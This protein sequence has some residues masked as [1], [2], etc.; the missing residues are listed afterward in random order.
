MRAN[1]RTIRNPEQLAELFATADAEIRRCAFQ[2]VDL[3][4]QAD[5]ALAHTYRDCLFIGCPLPMGLKRQ[6]R[7]CLFF[8]DMGQTFRYRNHLYTAEELY[9]GFDPE[10]PS[11]FET[12][13]DSV[14]Y[15]H[16]LKMGKRA[17]NVKETLARAM[18]D[19]SISDSL[20]D[21]LTQFDQRRLVGIMG[22]HG[23]ERTSAEYRQTVLLSKLLTE[24]GFLMITGGGPGAMEATHLGAWMAGRTS[25]EVDDAMRILSVA[26]TFRDEGWLSTAFQVRSRYPQTQYQS[27]GI[28]TWLYGH[29]PSTPFATHIAK[30]FDNSIREDGI[31]TVA[32]GGIIYTPGSAGTL[33]EIFQEAVQN[34]YLSFGFASPMIFLGQTFW[35]EDVPVW[36]LIQHLVRT[37]RYK[38]LLLTLTDEPETVLR[39][40]QEFAEGQRD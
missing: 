10:R 39:T 22:G 34:H 14:V 21:Y 12:C 25:A 16:F 20:Q 15:R 28:P 24:N 8:P 23:L 27:L 36:P 3:T 31:L 38:N 1:Y 40:L 7:D 6:S 37:G 19:Q 32:T 13:F 30:Y 11:T 9:E 35:T 33:Q 26:P 17:V 4:L 29:E 18:H 2:Q 5:Q